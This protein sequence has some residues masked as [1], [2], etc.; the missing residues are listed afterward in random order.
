[1]SH[2]ATQSDLDNAEL[3]LGELLQLGSDVNLSFEAGERCIDANYGTVRALRILANKTM[4]AANGSSGL[5]PMLRTARD[6]ETVW[7]ACKY[8]MACRASRALRR[9]GL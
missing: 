2:T 1:M 5:P 9:R 8:N 3:L 6:A 7:E 4:R